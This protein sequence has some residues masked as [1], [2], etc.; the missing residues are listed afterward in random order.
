MVPIGK[1]RCREVM[2]KRHLCGVQTQTFDINIV[3]TQWLSLTVSGHWEWTNSA[4]SWFS[5]PCLALT[6]LPIWNHSES[7]PA[8][9]PI[10]V[11]CTPRSCFQTA[12]SPN[13]LT[14]GEGTYATSKLKSHII[15]LGCFRNRP[16]LKD[17]WPSLAAVARYTVPM[18]YL[19]LLHVSCC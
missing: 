12:D 1:K 13:T 7:F 14:D 9:K 4:F 8:N 17:Q 16:E 19:M 10:E 11:E 15:I 6:S 18:G 3:A 2:S 5:P